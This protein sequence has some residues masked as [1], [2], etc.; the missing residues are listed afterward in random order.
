VVY[1]Y[2]VVNPNELRFDVRDS[3]EEFVTGIS[4]IKGDGTT[5]DRPIQEQAP[6]LMDE[7][8]M[9]EEMMGGVSLE[10]SPPLVEIVPV[11]PPQYPSF[12]ID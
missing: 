9:M 10:P 12:Q 1:A 2:F 4:E 5:D 7:L 3:F 11:E 8:A 6:A